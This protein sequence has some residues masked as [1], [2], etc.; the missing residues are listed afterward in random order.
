MELRGFEPVADNGNTQ[1]RS[2]IGVRESIGEGWRELGECRGALTLSIGVEACGCVAT[3]LQWVYGHLRHESVGG[4]RRGVTPEPERSRLLAAAKASADLRNA[5]QAAHK[6]GG[7]I[8]DIAQLSGLSTN[9]IQ[10]WLKE[11]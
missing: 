10:R 1:V 6:A 2:E 4:V 8:R 7:S 5:V 3:S 11:K 9:T